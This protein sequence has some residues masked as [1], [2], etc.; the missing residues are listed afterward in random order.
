VNA[1][2]S[3]RVIDS[4]IFVFFDE[5]KEILAPRI[6]QVMEDLIAEFF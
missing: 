6:I 3:D 4:G 1:V 2:T 5:F